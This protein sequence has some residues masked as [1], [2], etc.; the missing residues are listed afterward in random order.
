MTSWISS[1]KYLLL[2]QFLSRKLHA[3]AGSRYNQERSLN[4][5]ND[6]IY[7]TSVSYCHLIHAM[8]SQHITFSS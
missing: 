4:P 5:S 8:I 7:D 6:A 3:I 1:T 2:L